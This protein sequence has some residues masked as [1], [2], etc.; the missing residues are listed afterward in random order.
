MFLP[1]AILVMW[2]NIVI[3]WS[4]TWMKTITLKR[5]I[6][7]FIKSFVDKTCVFFVFFED[8]GAFKTAM[9]IRLAGVGQCLRFAFS[10]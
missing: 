2:H 5:S 7:Q 6:Y 10:G 8:Y 4:V 9:G 3:T 1:S